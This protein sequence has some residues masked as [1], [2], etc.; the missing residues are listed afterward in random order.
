M[1]RF[2]VMELSNERISQLIATGL[3]ACG[4]RFQEDRDAADG[5]NMFLMAKG[6]KIA[7]FIDFEPELMVIS[8][9]IAAGGFAGKG[10]S[11]RC[12]YAIV[13][14]EGASA[15]TPFL[16]PGCVLSYGLSTR[17]TITVSSMDLR[18]I[19]L[20]LQREM[21]TMDGKVLEQQEIPLSA[22]SSDPRSVMAASGALMLLGVPP[23]L[24]RGELS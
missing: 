15:V 10:R 12:K 24:L 11:L 14:G 3:K 7:D 5:E 6:K 16:R 17:D 19:V 23:K 1:R 8:P 21:V 22:G 13:P 20:S 2:G 9:K 18:S 4:Y